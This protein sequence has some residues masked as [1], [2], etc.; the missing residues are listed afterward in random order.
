MSRHKQVKKLKHRIKSLKSKIRVLTRKQ[1]DKHEV[2]EP[3]PSAYYKYMDQRTLLLLLKNKTIKFTDPLKFNDPM[4]SAVPDIQING[5]LLKKAMIRELES[6]FG[7]DLN[8][9]K[10]EIDK[11]ITR[12]LPKLKRDFSEF[13][14]ELRDKW[15][16]I[17][18]HYRILS[19]TA[20]NDNLLM[21]SH[22]A[23]EHR[24]VVV[25]FKSNPSIGI[26][27][28]VDY[29]KGHQSL[30]NFFNNMMALIIK[31]EARSGFSDS[32]SNVASELTVRAMF[33]YFF[34]KRAEWSYENEY[35]I[36][37]RKCSE[38]IV[39]IND[40]LDVVKFDEKDI[41]SVIIGSSVTPHRAKRLKLL[42]S[43]RI[44]HVKVTK[45][46]IVGWNLKYDKAF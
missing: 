25:K 22:Y 3:Q 2:I 20:K 28:K 11:E 33:K 38:R 18:S 12:D 45:Y 14:N 39:N 41:E 35:R 5:N 44:P 40:N 16:E 6:Q 37:Y 24:G 19:L 9:R 4:D 13:S 7:D 1:I 30:N 26:P 46:Q 42:I 27:K 36:V 29:F 10:S 34:M 15:P 43:R 17:I 32:H 8:E 21:W 31:K 23:D